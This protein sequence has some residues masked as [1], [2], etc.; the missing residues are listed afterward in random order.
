MKNSNAVTA[1]LLVLLL[2][3]CAALLLVCG[4]SG[5]ARYEP[6]QDLKGTYCEKLAKLPAAHPR[7]PLPQD[8]TLAKWT[9]DMESAIEPMLA[10]E[11]LESNHSPRHNPMSGPDEACSKQLAETLKKNLPEK[12]PILQAHHVEQEDCRSIDKFLG[13]F[14]DNARLRRALTSIYRCCVEDNFNSIDGVLDKNEPFLRLTAK[15]FPERLGI[16]FELLTEDDWSV[17][18]DSTFVWTKTPFGRTS[19]DLGPTGNALKVVRDIAKERPEMLPLLLPT[20]KKW[21]DSSKLP[22]HRRARWQALVTYIEAGAP[23]PGEAGSAELIRAMERDVGSARWALA[24]LPNELEE[25]APRPYPYIKDADLIR[26]VTARTTSMTTATTRE[27][28]IVLGLDAVSRMPPG[29]A[30]DW[31]ASYLHSPTKGIWEAA[32]SAINRQIEQLPLDDGREKITD[33]EAYNLID[34]DEPKRKTIAKFLKP[35]QDVLVLSLKQRICVDYEAFDLV[36]KA[37]DQKIDADFVACLGPDPKPIAKSPEFVFSACLQRREYGWQLTGKALESM[38]A[39][40]DSG[41]YLRRI[42]NG[43]RTGKD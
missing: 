40:G 41:N 9:L 26:V 34:R 28:D 10:Q 13:H 16:D 21:A 32:I 27:E 14:P 42:A 43:C 3:G 33:E 29:T 12:Q 30:L 6:T 20:A 25:H 24:F 31:I 22:S 8:A 1:I 5:K 2:G 23:D 36:L 11:A 4:K 35:V 17:K 38:A 37:D 19:L 7:G 15:V 39:P 18:T